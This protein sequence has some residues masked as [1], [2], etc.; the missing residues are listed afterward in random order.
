MLPAVPGT[1]GP[2]PASRA[3]AG[4]HNTRS[5]PAPEALPRGRGATRR[6]TRPLPRPCPGTEATRSSLSA[7]PP[8]P[9]FE[10]AEQPLVLTSI[11]P[12]GS[13]MRVRCPLSTKIQPCSQA[14]RFAS[15]VRS[16]DAISRSV[17]SVRRANSPSCGVKIVTRPRRTS[18]FSVQPCKAFQTV[19][20]QHQRLFHLPQKRVDELLCL[21]SAAK[22]GTER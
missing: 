7:R 11:R 16:L 18:S 5:F 8:L 6:A 15:S 2:V 14:K 3:P 12:S 13:A 19:G 21:F 17:R 9:P 1:R 20:V 4:S 10:S 22:A